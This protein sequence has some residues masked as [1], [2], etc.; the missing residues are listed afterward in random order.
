MYICA[1]CNAFTAILLLYV[2]SIIDYY[3]F[4]PL[5]IFSFSKMMQPL[6]LIQKWPVRNAATDGCCF[7]C[8]SVV[9]KAGCPH[10]FNCIICTIYFQF[11]K[12]THEA[13]L[14]PLEGFTPHLL[15]SGRVC[16]TLSVHFWVSTHCH[17]LIL[18]R[19]DMC[20]RGNN[21]MQQHFSSFLFLDALKLNALMLT[22]KPMCVFSVQLY[23]WTSSGFVSVLAEQ[24]E[25]PVSLLILHYT[26]GIQWRLNPAVV[27]P[28]TTRV[29]SSI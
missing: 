27:P 10:Q 4:F 20:Y 22:L 12:C 3:F 8:T 9:S 17:W 5:D 1:R 11:V 24:E 2:L 7:L 18:Q 29:N 25:I 23:N 14:Y 15:H 26:F 16:N 19:F 6:H 13:I 21:C 28:C